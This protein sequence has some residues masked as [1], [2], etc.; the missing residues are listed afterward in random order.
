M[1]APIGEVVVSG[2]RYCITKILR[3]STSV[4]A[5]QA[6]ELR[7]RDTLNLNQYGLALLLDEKLG[8]NSLGLQGHPLF[9]LCSPRLY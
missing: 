5:V 4:I 8:R 3:H 9:L 2:P 1:V 6:K 7:R